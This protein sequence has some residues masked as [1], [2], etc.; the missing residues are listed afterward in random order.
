MYKT[1]RLD[2][3]TPDEMTVEQILDYYRDNEEFLK[4][5]EP[6][7]TP[8]FYTYRQQ[9]IDLENDRFYYE[10]GSA[11]KLFLCLVG[12]SKVIGILNFSQIIMGPFKSCYLGY[13]LLKAYCKQGFMSEAVE[14]GI[15]II[16]EE[17]GL[18]RIEA[19]VMPSNEA[20][21]QLLKKK[22]FQYEGVARRYLCINGQWEDHA[23]YTLLNE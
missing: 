20:S 5:F 2:L 8:S 22:G 16:F 4:P 3:R 14:K 13:S 18:H 17:Y 6:F 10:H 23:H 1:T 9:S 12:T 19:N 7:R 11:M 15:E 21:I